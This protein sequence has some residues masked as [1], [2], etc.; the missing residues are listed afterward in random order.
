MYLQAMARLDAAG[1]TQYE[2]SNVSRPGRQ[3]RHNLKYWTDQEWLGFGCGAHSTRKGAREKN[4]ASISEY[5]TA[6]RAGRSLVAERRTLCNQDRFEEAVFTGLRLTEGI[7]LGQVESRYGID[8]WARYGQ[9][10]QPFVDQRLLIYDD[11]SL[12]LTREGM[13]LANE[14]MAV[15]IRLSVR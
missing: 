7:R 3:S 6:V 15:F 1:Y 10:L 13:L 2:I 9:E 11:G 14:V 8:V 5:N 4:I 12:R